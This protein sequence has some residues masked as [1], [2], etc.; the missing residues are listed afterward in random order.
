M[1]ILIRHHVAVV[2]SAA[3][4]VCKQ[5]MANAVEEVKTFYEPQEDGKFDIGVSG[6]GTW[7]KKGYSSP[8]G[9]VTALS[10]IM[11][12]V[13]DVEVMSKNNKEC[14][15]W[16]G[17][18]GTQEFQDQWEVHQHLCEANFLGSPEAMDASW[19]LASDQP[20]TIK[21]AIVNF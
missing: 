20:R 9:V 17:K 4:A 3:Q 5:S 1:K 2:R 15:G 8:Y 14:N 6:D 7:R 16:R 10:T 19:L 11:G 13:V 21:F 12:K 18:E